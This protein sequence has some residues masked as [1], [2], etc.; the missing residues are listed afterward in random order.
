MKRIFAIKNSLIMSRQVFAGPAPVTYFKQ[1]LL[2]LLWLF[3]LIA[4]PINAATTSRQ[5]GSGMSWMRT[6]DINPDGQY[7]L[8]GQMGMDTFSI[9]NSNLNDYDLFTGIGINYGLFDYLEAGLLASY[10]TNDESKTSGIRHLKAIAKLK[11]LGSEQDGYAATVSAFTTTATADVAD[12]LGSDESENGFEANLTYYGKDLNLHLTYGSAT[13]DFR[14]YLPDLVFRGI[15]KTYLAVGAEFKLSDVYTLGIENISESSDDTGFDKNQVFA[16]SLQYHLAPEWQIDFGSAFGVPEDRA[17][18]IK[19]F[20]LGLSYTP[21]KQRSAGLSTPQTR[22]TTPAKLA[23]APVTARP[24]VKTKP[25]TAAKKSTTKKAAAKGGKKLRI[26]LINASGSGA[27]ARRTADFLRGKG[28]R[29]VSI[30]K[31]ATIR[32][33]TE[34]RH[35]SKYSREALQ[36]ALKIPGSQNLRKAGKIGKGADLELTIGKDI[37]QQI[38]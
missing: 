29:V 13:T 35:T 8:Y 20:Y 23:S 15:D 21:G 16:L 34:I 9:T 7:T 32:S 1:V 2:L 30:K 26:K 24:Q 19:S 33:K 11:L 14:E 25:V 12:R 6:A 38:R 36:L 17:E 3:L 31:A 22:Q 37:L 18:P 10:V 5:G 27:M 4:Q 28:Y